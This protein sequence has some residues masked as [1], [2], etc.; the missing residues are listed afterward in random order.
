MY[1]FVGVITQN[2]NISDKTFRKTH[3][4]NIRT[5]E[6]IPREN[7][8]NISKIDINQVVLSKSKDIYV[9]IED[10]TKYTVKSMRHIFGRDVFL[11]IDRLATKKTIN[12]N[13]INNATGKQFII[14]SDIKDYTEYKYIL[15]LDGII[16]DI[17][18]SDKNT[19]E[20]INNSVINI[21]YKETEDIE[22]L[23]KDITIN[24]INHD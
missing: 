20:Q 8:V 13:N 21:Y 6:I 24:I 19:W 16:I 15:D 4:I 22:D 11:N 1:D 2:F 3:C 17:K 5:L 14:Y 7:D 12:F 10:F 18:K 23:I 9:S